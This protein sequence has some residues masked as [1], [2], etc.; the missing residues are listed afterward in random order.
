MLVQ[1]FSQDTTQPTSQFVIPTASPARPVD[2][3]LLDDK[4]RFIEGF[5]AFGMD[6]KDLC[7]VPNMVLP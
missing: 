2:Y 7:L 5:S 1:A 6:A 3:Q 4:I